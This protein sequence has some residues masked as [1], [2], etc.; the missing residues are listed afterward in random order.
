MITA[1]ESSDGTYLPARMLNEFVY[2]PRLFYYEHVEG[3]FAHNRET[4][5]GAGLH[6]RVDAKSDPFPTPEALLEQGERG[7]ARSIQLAS[8]TLGIIAKL[9]MLETDGAQVIPVDYKRGKPRELSDGSIVAWD[10]DQVQIGA[11][12]LILR[13]LGYECTQAYLWYHGSRQRVL[14][15]IDETLERTVRETIAAARAVAVSNQIPEPLEDSPK[16]PRCSLVGICL[17]DETR[18]CHEQDEQQVYQPTLFDIE[19]PRSAV[20]RERFSPSPETTRRLVPARDDLRPLYLN[21]PGLTVGKSGQVLKVKSKTTTVEEVR[22][23]D[24][25]QI[26]LFGN[27]QLT[28]QAIQTA[29]ELE[30]P[31]AYFSMGGWFYGVTRG[32]GL[33]NIFVRREQFRLADNQGFALRFSQGL[34]EGK[35]RNQRTL[36]MRNHVEP[37]KGAL[38]QLK[39]LQQEVKRCESLG[40]LMGIEGN[41]AAIYFRHFSGMLKVESNREEYPWG[42]FLDSA[43]EPPVSERAEGERHS[44]SGEE[45]SSDEESGEPITEGLTFHF[46]SRNRRPPRDPIN[47]MLSLAYALLAK[48]LMITCSAVGLDPYLGFMHQ[49]RYGRASLAL[50]LMEPF[51][52]LIADSVVLTAVN[53][54]MV[55]VS[56][57]VRAGNAV[58]LKSEGRKR[59]FMAYEQRMDTLVTHPLFGYRVSY[60]RLLEIQTRLLTRMLTGEISQY[61]VFTTR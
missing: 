20:V 37:P 52:P 34:I 9:D 23:R 22:L 18:R 3:V 46:E 41:A 29:C 48:D 40:E 42:G 1:R 36:L 14:V 6:S 28:T 13:E 59:F 15:R 33:T 58:S 43:C 11:Q 17:P 61:P 25:S 51:R 16:C 26:N 56:D 57:F 50:D 4:V 5:E 39:A 44:E 53:N 12:A 55:T 49:P 19:A 38:V 21:T 7:K 8:D 32:L 54:R 27:I 2:C 30:I 31:I 47:A 24:V 45:D 10:A 35:I 60:R